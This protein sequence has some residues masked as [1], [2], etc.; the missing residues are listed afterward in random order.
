LKE[1]I[2]KK[3]QRNTKV[4]GG[5]ILRQ[6]FV[7]SPETAHPLWFPVPSE[8]RASLTNGDGKTVCPHVKSETMSLSL[9][10]Y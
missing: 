6:M 8:K 2:K 7:L 9:T 4:Y 5:S 10:L 3:T 1:K